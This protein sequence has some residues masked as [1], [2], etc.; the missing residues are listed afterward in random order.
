MALVLR[1]RARLLVI[2][3]AVY[4]LSLLQY[5]RG[6]EA[7]RLH[8]QEAQIRLLAPWSSVTYSPKNNCEPG[9]IAFLKLDNKRVLKP[10]PFVHEK[11]VTAAGSSESRAVY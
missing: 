1:R 8:A 2:F 7:L 11:Q 10:H 4:P 6:S 5:P 9:G 3:G